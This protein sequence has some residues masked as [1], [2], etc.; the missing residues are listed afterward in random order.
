ML[1]ITQ[2]NNVK[3]QLERLHYAKGA[4]DY[5]LENCHPKKSRFRRANLRKAVAKIE[6]AISALETASLS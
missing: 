6:E 5:L 2:Y 1:P 3:E 4:L